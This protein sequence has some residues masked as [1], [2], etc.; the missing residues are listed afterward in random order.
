M[1]GDFLRRKLVEYERL[2]Q[3]IDEL[4]AESGEGQGK[5]RG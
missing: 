3:E 2:R 4:T 1:T 5:G